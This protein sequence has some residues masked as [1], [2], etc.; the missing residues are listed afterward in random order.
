MS[1]KNNG[2]QFTFDDSDVSPEQQE[3]LKRFRHDLETRPIRALTTEERNIYGAAIFI[4]RQ[5]LPSFRDALAV[6]S[7]FMDATAT[8]AYTDKYA[9]VGLSYWF[10]YL[11]DTETRAFALLH[12]SMHVLNSHFARS[13]SMQIKPQMMNFSGDLEINSN[14]SVINGFQTI[15]EDYLIPKKF[16]FP[17]FQTM[18][19]YVSMLNKKMDE[20][21]EA[22]NNADQSSSD[23]K[24]DNQNSD[25]DDSSSS[26]GNSDSSQGTEESSSN[27]GNEGNSNNGSDGDGDAQGNGQS[28]A[29]DSSSNGDPSEASGYGQAYDHY[30]DELRGRKG[31]GGNPLDALKNER[32]NQE[33]E[34]YEYGN[35]ESDTPDNGEG[36]SFGNE[37]SSNSS[38]SGKKKSVKVPRPGFHTCDKNTDEREQAADDAG[39]EKSSITEQ[40][41]A[42]R[43]TMSRMVDEVNHNKSRGD[44][45]VNDFLKIAISHMSPPKI[46]WRDVFRRTLALTMNNAVLGRDSLSYRRVN[47][48][49][50][51]GSV[52][53]PGYVTYLP[54]AMFAIDTSGS[55]DKSDYASLLT[56]I[57]EIVKKVMNSK[58]SL[59]VFSVDTT[60][61]NV[62][63]VKNVKNIDLFGGGGTDM[64]VAFAYV[65]SLPK[66]KRPDIMI[67]GTDGYTDWDR[68]ERQLQFAKYRSIILVTTEGGFKSVPQSL[69][70]YAAVIDISSGDKQS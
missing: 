70:N 44:G 9:R 15:V 12:E 68:V 37:G 46:N 14:L 59:Q 50:S 43:N 36:H 35:N 45:S 66:K 64:S 5:K 49:Y 27:D 21:E 39:I 4:A 62:Q 69:K 67:L 16:D 29:G 2:A 53:L 60:I 40:N 32:N 11:A 7:P 31:E 20:E 61:K 38:S 24:S 23:G 57:E 33:T 48:R 54:K 63:L 51:Q 19:Q 34:S 1:E 17:D 26:T 30:S 47:R 25:S 8:T 10:F 28:S 6:L 52:I 42:R 22:E 18:E 3:I 55:M 58:D 41:I 13:D 65:N 56:E